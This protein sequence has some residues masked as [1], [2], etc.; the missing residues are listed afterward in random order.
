MNPRQ[1]VRYLP[2]YYLLATLILLGALSGC[3]QYPTPTPPPGAAQ[4][5]PE[6][7]V[8]PGFRSQIYPQLKFNCGVCHDYGWLNFTGDPDR[9]HA[10]I[11][12]M[13]DSDNPEGSLLLAMA[14]DQDGI[15]PGGRVF[16]P[17]TQLHA[18][19][20]AWIKAGAPND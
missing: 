4:K 9:D 13:V 2:K 15:H 11:K 1:K 19:L 14:T 7:P 10:D 8:I 16:A 6:P 3:K 20:I 18:Q 17:N 5:V 12:T